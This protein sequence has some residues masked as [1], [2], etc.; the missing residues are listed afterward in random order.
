M[1]CNRCGKE[2]SDDATFC[3][4]C[5]IKFSSGN[6]IT[7]MTGTYCPKCGSKNVNSTVENDTYGGGYNFFKG[8]LLGLLIGPLGYFCGER[9]IK[10]T[11]RT[12]MLCMDCSHK[13]REAND[14]ANEK[15]K[16]SALR[17]IWSI[18]FILFG[19]FY[20][21]ETEVLFGLIVLGIGVFLAYSGY[22]LKKES[23]DIISN[24]YNSSV[25]KE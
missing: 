21:K 22:K 20:V 18:I 3:Q 16:Q 25:Y 4:F 6:V 23:E 13:F 17:I 11:T 14:L 12:Y 5:G 8:C 9:K 15:S 24:K 1:F 2:V 7:N 10:T 19:L